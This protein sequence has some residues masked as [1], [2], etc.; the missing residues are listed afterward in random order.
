MGEVSVAAAAAELGVSKRQVTRLARAGDLDVTREVGGVLLLDSSSVHRWAQ[1]RRL[2]GRPWSEAVAWAALAVLSGQD[3]DW[4]SPSQSTRLRH[5]L[6]RSDAEDVAFFAR[7]RAVTLRMRSWGGTDEYAIGQYFTYTGVSALDKES[8]MA[9]RFGLA[10][11][12]SGRTDGYVNADELD[13]AVEN[14]GLTDD[15]DGD[16]TV[17]VVTG[18]NP[19]FASIAKHETTAVAATTNAAEAV[20]IAAVALDLMESLDTRERSAGARVLQELIDALP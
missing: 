8:G 2:S 15:L 19:Y 17:R 5:R 20:S 10:T 12:R 9:S 18:K 3:A 6:R 1:M 7:R 14:L 4:I 13:A 16:M 11:I